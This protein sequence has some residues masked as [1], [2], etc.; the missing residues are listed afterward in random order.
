MARFYTLSSA[1]CKGREWHV[2]SLHDSHVLSL[3]NLFYTYMCCIVQAYTSWL[4]ALR[5]NPSILTPVCRRTML[6]YQ[7]LKSNSMLWAFGLTA[8][9]PHKSIKIARI[10]MRSF[11]NFEIWGMWQAPSCKRSFVSVTCVSGGLEES[12]YIT[13]DEVGLFSTRKVW[14]SE[15]PS[16]VAISDLS[17]RN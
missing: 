11:E 1:F 2:R 16:A 4:Y 13:I 17:R 8:F 12:C 6:V 7:D 5:G 10:I 3:I 9:T 14:V 15:N